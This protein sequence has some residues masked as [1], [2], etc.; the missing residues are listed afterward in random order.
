MS[1]PLKCYFPPSG[2]M[3]PEPLLFANFDEEEVASSF[4]P[5][6]GKNPRG[7]I[8]HGLPEAAT[9]FLWKP[10]PL[11]DSLRGGYEARYEVQ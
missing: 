2:D 11:P 3:E 10:V 7:L 8:V 5:V 9:T 1:V 6:P 4:S